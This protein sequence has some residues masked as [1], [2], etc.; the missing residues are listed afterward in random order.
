MSQIENAG[1]KG[2]GFGMVLLAIAGIILLLI[3]IYHHPANQPPIEVT[4]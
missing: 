1:K 2:A 4:G 3:Y